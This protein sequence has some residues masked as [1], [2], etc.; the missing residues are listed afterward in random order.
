V[1]DGS[2]ILFPSQKG[3]AMTQMQFLRLFRKYALAVGVSP[4]HAHPHIL[5]HSLCSAIAAQHADLYAIQQRAGHKN[6][7]NTMIYTHVSDEQ[8]SES[9]RQALMIAFG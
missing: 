8:A 5:R 1:E 7:S 2:R 6:I 3:G 9:C 4:N